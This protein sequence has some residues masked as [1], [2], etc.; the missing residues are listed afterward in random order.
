MDA[1]RRSDFQTVFEALNLLTTALK[2]LEI[3]GISKDISLAV[4]CTEFL[5]ICVLIPRTGSTWHLVPD[6]KIEVRFGLVWFGLEFQQAFAQNGGSW[7]CYWNK[8]Q[9]ECHW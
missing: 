5:G 1:D 3:L 9:Y 4:S 6:M 2:R 8:G 7:D